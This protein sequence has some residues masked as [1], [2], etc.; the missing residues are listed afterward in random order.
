MISIRQVIADI[1]R[2]FRSWIKGRKELHR[3]IKECKRFER[4]LIHTQDTPRIIYMGVTRQRNLGDLAQHYCI[5]Q[6]IKNYCSDYAL[7]TID[8]PVVVNKPQFLIT[9]A[10][11]I[12]SKDVIVFQS[13]Y[14]TQDLGG[15]HDLM[16]RMVAKSIPQANILMMPQTIFFQKEINKQKTAVALNNCSNMLFLARD[17]T[18]FEIAKEMFPNIKVI[19]YPDIVTSLIGKYSFNNLRD[20]IYLCR[21]TD[22]EK[23][24]SEENLLALKDKLSLLAPVEMGDTKSHATLP[25]ILRDLKGHIE[26]EIEKYSHYKVTITDRYHGTIFSLCAGTPVVI[27]K[28]TDHKVTTGADWFIDIYDKY[29]TVAESLDEAYCLAENIIKNKKEYPTLQPYY[30]KKYY[31]KALRKLFNETFL[32]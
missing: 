5:S 15:D 12:T 30:A 19:A 13:G 6:W 28:T 8:S 22:R 20:K 21:R 11:Y 31:E 3:R 29:V 18:S 7:L 25:Q 2:P 4:E 10:R 16:H 14:T 1:T 17:F 9:L 32:Q 27:I 23:F 26:E 24:Y